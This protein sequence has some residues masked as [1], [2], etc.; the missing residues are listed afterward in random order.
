MDLP[1]VGL[2]GFLA[3]VAGATAQILQNRL[4]SRREEQRWIANNRKEEYRELL[5][6]LTHTATFLMEYRGIPSTYENTEE[7]EFRRIYGDG[8]RVLADR[9][10]IADEIKN[11]EAYDRWTNAIKKLGQTHDIHA[12]SDCFERLRDDIVKAARKNHAS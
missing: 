5:K 7:E 2:G 3:I 1:S 8:I 4:T 10:Y 11:I 6:T 9:I 12:F